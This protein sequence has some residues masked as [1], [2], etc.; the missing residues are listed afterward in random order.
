MVLPEVLWLTAGA[1]AAASAEIDSDADITI[2]TEQLCGPIETKADSANLGNLCLPAGYDVQ[3]LA[4]VFKVEQ[5]G[6]GGCGGAGAIPK[7]AIDDIQECA[8]LAHA[9]GFNRI[10]FVQG[11]QC[12]MCAVDDAGDA[13]NGTSHMTVAPAGTAEL[14]PTC[15]TASAGHY[16]L[17]CSTSTL[18][19]TALAEKD[20]L[21]DMQCAGRNFHDKDARLGLN[22][23]LHSLQGALKVAE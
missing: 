1:L 14:P 10:N 22:A 23:K 18:G 17:M 8:A 9:D 16:C 2:N 11:Q 4:L 3:R 5:T 20:R 6:K 7:P 21:I 12:V 13:T 19:C 15:E